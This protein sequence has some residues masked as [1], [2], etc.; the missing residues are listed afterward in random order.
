MNSPG[1]VVNTSRGAVINTVDLIEALGNGKLG[2]ACLD[3]YEFEKGLFFED[4]R[5]DVIHDLNFSKL[6]SFNNVLITCHQGFLTEDAITEIAETTIANIDA[7]QNGIRC[8]NQLN[9][10]D[11]GKVEIESTVSTIQSL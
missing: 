8:K 6:R 7:F 10:R 11:N 1:I 2:G 4:R 9:R 3:V 5:G